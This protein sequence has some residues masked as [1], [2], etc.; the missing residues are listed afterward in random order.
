MAFDKSGLDSYIQVNERIVKFYERYPEGSLQSEIVKLEADRVVMKALAY[1]TPDDAR[2]GIGYSSLQIPGPTPYTRHSEIE[3]AETSAWG[4]ALAALGFEVKRGVASRDE[5]ENKSAATAPQNTIGCV[6]TETGEVRT[7]ASILPADV[8]ISIEHQDD[9]VTWCMENRIDFYSKVAP[10]FGV[11]TVADLTEGQYAQWEQKKHLMLP[12]TDPRAV[13]DEVR[14]VFPD[15]TVV[16]QV[17]D[18]GKKRG[19]VISEAQG[20]R[21]FAIADGNRDLLAKVMEPYGYSHTKDILKSDYEAICA[22]AEAGEVP[23]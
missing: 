20:R 17:I 14:A 5:I 1:R 11:E 4:R 8:R 7:F 18:A 10:S 3:N 15:A 19:P 13:E 9:V 6:N 21:L 2:P 16:K 12:K 22:A 23:F